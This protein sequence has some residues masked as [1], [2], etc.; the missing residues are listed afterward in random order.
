[1][2]SSSDTYRA[3]N[4]ETAHN[5]L[6]SRVRFP[7]RLFVGTDM[8]ARINWSRRVAPSLHACESESGAS[9]AIA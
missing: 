7:L 6:G 8:A 5:S 9:I 3:R 2:P 1:M 4:L